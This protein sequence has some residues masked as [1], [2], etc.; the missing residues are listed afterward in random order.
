MEAL[1]S[2]AATLD[3]AVLEFGRLAAKAA[4]G[5]EQRPVD[6]LTEDPDLRF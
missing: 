5:S 1:L 3:Y 4:A 6:R 2:H